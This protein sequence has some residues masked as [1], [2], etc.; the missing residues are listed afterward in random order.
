MEMVH[1]KQF[2]SNG[3]G[4]E[5][6]IEII[7]QHKQNEGNIAVV[8]SARQQATD[9][10]ENLLQ[11]A[12]K[13]V[14]DKSALKEFEKYQKSV[15]SSIDYSQ[16]ITQLSKRLE[17]VSLVGDYS[18]K[19]KDEVL[20]IG[21]LISCRL[22]VSILKERGINAVL[23]DARELL[24]T[25][26]NFGDAQI[27]EK[28]SKTKVLQ[29]FENLDSDSVPIITGFIA[30][31]EKGETTTLGRNGSNYTAAL[32]ANYLDAVEVLNYTHVDGIFT[33]NP[34]YVSQAKIIENLSYGEANELANFGANVLHAKTII[35]LIEKNIPLRILNTFNPISKGTL[36][37]SKTKKEGI[38]S[39][40]VI[41]D[42]AMI[43]L[44]GRGLLGKVGIDARIFTSLGRQNINVSIISQGSSERG[45]G[46]V[47]SSVDA[48]AA[49]K[50]L[51]TEFAT[52]FSAQ[53]N[54]WRK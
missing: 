21:E 1:L 46:L 13:G 5:R 22:V 24:Q 29:R 35:P 20:S 25:D 50:A 9:T 36:I 37:S 7:H 6:V 15:S 3:H 17:G 30:S 41:E 10:L 28:V 42:V 19:T 40:S 53:A 32:F 26:S 54:I 16:E 38:K 31:N 14:L 4:L 23:I 39:L 34:D 2:R 43:N 12:S 47:V 8:L 48:R 44:E 11:N 45:I 33:A 18:L 27:I 51:D 49:K 52:D